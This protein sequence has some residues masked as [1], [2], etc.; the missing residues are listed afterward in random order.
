MGRHVRQWRR[1]MCVMR[2]VRFIILF[3][4]GWCDG[5]TNAN[6]SGLGM[7]CEACAGGND[8]EVAAGTS[9]LKRSDSDELV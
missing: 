2:W 4:V 1:I 3:V 7:G 9:V 8:V 6:I 5:E